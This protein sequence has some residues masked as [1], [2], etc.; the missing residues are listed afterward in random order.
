M[1]EDGDQILK[2][3]IVEDFFTNSDYQL[4]FWKNTFTTEAGTFYIP[5]MSGAGG[6]YVFSMPN[7]LVGIALGCNNYNFGWNSVQQLTI[8][9]AANNIDPF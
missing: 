5:H 8:V 1:T 4:A 3:E 7:G 6:N 9:E 2:K